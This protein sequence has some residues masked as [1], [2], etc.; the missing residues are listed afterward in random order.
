[1]IF[2]FVIIIIIIIIIIVVYTISTQDGKSPLDLAHANRAYFNTQ[3]V[4]E[5]FEAHENKPQAQTK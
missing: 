2:K 3:G 5:I 1:M 4:I